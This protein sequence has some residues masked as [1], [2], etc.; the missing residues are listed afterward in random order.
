MSFNRMNYDSCTYAQNL[1]QSLSVGEY[2]LDMP[3][4]NCKTCFSTDPRNAPGIG[5]AV[6][7]CSD[8]PLVDVDSELLGI[9]RRASKCPSQNYLPKA[10][11]Y[12]VLRGVPDC[13]S[14]I[15]TE[16]T[17][18]S[19]PPCTLRGTGWNRWEWL[20]KDP[21]E[22]ALVPFDFMIANKL[23]VKDNHRPC[24]PT[25]LDPSLAM[26]GQGKCQMAREDAWW[27]T[28]APPSSCA[29][30]AVHENLPTVSWRSAEEIARY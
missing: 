30:Q 24:L 4:Y 27:G 28:L 26:P 29:G 13:E 12:C 9:S 5:S 19:N 17:R 10:D 11:G 14:E 20:C 16:D 21:Q 1:K 23:I 18:I 2:M 3:R 22:G 15:R 7:R 8:K 6:A 25:P